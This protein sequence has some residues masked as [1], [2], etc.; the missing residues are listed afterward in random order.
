MKTVFVK[1]LSMWLYDQLITLWTEANLPFK[2][3]GRDSY[4]SLSNRLEQ[5]STWLMV[6][7]D[8]TDNIHELE[9]KDGLIGAVIVTHDGQ[10]GW[11]NRLAIHPKHRKKGYAKHLLEKCEQFLRTQGIYL[12]AALV[13]KTNVPSLNLFQSSGYRVHDE[14]LYLSKRDSM[15]Y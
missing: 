12:F 1:E 5:T 11:I 9:L 13:E 3:K 10:R 8:D 14:L 6:A 4:R 15:D 2:P 7:I